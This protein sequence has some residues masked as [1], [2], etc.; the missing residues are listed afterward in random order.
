MSILDIASEYID[1]GLSVIPVK[2]DGSKAPAFTGWR[3]YTTKL[4]ADET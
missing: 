1:A 3:A 2:A 4:A